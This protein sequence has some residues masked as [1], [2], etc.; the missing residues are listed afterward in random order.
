MP[1]WAALAAVAVT[2]LGATGGALAVTGGTVDTTDTNVGALVGVVPSGAEQLF[3]SG[4]LIAPRVFLTA[5]QCIQNIE[6]LPGARVAA[7]FDTTFDAASPKLIFGTPVIS[8][9]SCRARA[10]PRISRS[11]CST[12]RPPGSRR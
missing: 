10:I 2:A 9:S 4:T 3:C 1:R 8:P 7:A 6:A 5:A 11:S 12:R